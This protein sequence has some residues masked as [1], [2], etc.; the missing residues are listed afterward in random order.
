MAQCV[1]CGEK[2][3]FLKVINKMCKS[4]SNTR[5]ESIPKYKDL[6]IKVLEDGIIDEN[7]QEE[8]DNFQQ[9]GCLLPKD[10][11]QIEINLYTEKYSEAI[12]D[13]LL[14]DEEEKELDNLR[15]LLQI[16]PNKSNV[17]ELIRLRALTKIQEGNF[18][19]IEEPSVMLQKN[20]TAYH[21]CSSKMYE[22]KQFKETKTSSASFRVK[23]VKGVYYSPPRTK[24]TYTREE[25]VVL[26]Q[27]NIAI[28]NKRII[29]S[30][31]KKSISL[32]FDKIINIEPFSDAI[33]IHKG[34]QKPLS[35]FIKDAE[36]FYI[37]L[38]S[39][40]NYNMN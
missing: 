9:A 34:T 38:I 40:M 8:L 25:N 24:T 30:G 31:G 14:T 6:L 11:K 10:I 33:V 27:G 22:L 15:E 36:L 32:K 3:S 20:E 13:R 37:T 21:E 12:S 28:T 1:F 29:F 19:I 4:C 18:P 23:I 39:S 16:P 2:I 17:N 35:F 7:E 26:D 5:K